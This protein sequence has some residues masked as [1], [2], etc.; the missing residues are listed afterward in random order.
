MAS[1][2]D[3][4]QFIADQCADAGRIVTRKMFGD[5]G[6]YCNDKIVGLICD[7]RLYLKP[8][9]AGK[10]LL[11]TLELRPPYEGAKDYFYIDD[12]DDHEYLSMLVRAT[13]KALP[14]PKPKKGM[15]T[16]K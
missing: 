2:P 8:T 12:V 13:C 3:L 1:N 10:A 11:H 7:N 5:Y 9:D 6:L 14:E 16:K 15:G 4:V